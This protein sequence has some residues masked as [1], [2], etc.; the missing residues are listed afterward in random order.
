[1]ATPHP[2]LF[3]KSGTAA[4]TV[5]KK[6]YAAFAVLA[7]ASAPPMILYVASVHKIFAIPVEVT[8]VTIVLKH[9]H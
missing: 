4:R 3:R 2:L 9:G 6:L 5:H 1:M 8:A 7:V